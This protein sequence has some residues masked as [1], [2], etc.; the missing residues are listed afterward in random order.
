MGTHCIGTDISVNPAIESRL[1]LAGKC[2]MQLTNQKSPPLK[3][4]AASDGSNTRSSNYADFYRRLA[5]LSLRAIAQP[6][7]MVLLAITYPDANREPTT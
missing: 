5:K 2:P 7:G 3:K 1:Q 4:C 6:Y